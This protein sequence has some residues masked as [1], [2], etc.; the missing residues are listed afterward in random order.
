M[1]NSD[2]NDAS[3]YVDAYHVTDY[4]NLWSLAKYGLKDLLSETKDIF[5]SPTLFEY[6]EINLL[7]KFKLANRDT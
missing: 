7:P 1:L 2:I 3:N 4:N 6:S 5:I